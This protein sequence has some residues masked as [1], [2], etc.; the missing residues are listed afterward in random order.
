MNRSQI[1]HTTTT[2][3]IRCIDIIIAL[4]LLILSAPII[5]IFSLIQKLRLRAAF[6]RI[7]L[8]DQQQQLLIVHRLAG[9]N[10]F[11]RLPELLQVVSGKLNLLGSPQRFS[12]ES[13]TVVTL[14]PG[15]IS[16]NDA[17]QKMGLNFQCQQQAL[18]DAHSSA[19]SY[20]LALARITIITALGSQSNLPQ[21]ETFELFGARINNVSMDD[22]L[23]QVMSA[24]TDNTHVSRYAFVNA[25]CMNIAFDNDTYRSSLETCKQVF[26][27][28]LGMRLAAKQAGI[29]LKDNVNGTDMFPLLCQQMAEQGLAIFLLGGRPGIAEQTAQNMQQQFPNLKVAGTH[30]GYL[31]DKQLNQSVIDKINQSGAAV[32]LVAMGAPMQELWLQK[33]QSELQVGVAMGVGGLFDFYSNRIKRAPMWVRQMG[34]EWICRLLAEPKR[35]WRRYIIGNPLF[36]YRVNRYLKQ[37]GAGKAAQT[38]PSQRALSTQGLAH[39]LA[40]QDL[41]YQKAVL[42][43]VT[44]KLALRLNIVAKRIVDVVVAS[45]A[46]LLLSPLFML[47]FMLIRIESPGAVFF[48]QQRAGK[49]NLPFKMWKFRSMY[50]DAQQ[51]LQKLQAQNEMQGGVTFKMKQDPRITRVGRFI[52][53][54]SIDE[55]PQLWNVLKGDMSLVGPRPALLSEVEQYSQHQRRRLNIKPGITCIWQV[56]GRSDIPFDKQVQLDI[57]YIY[58]QSLTADISLLLKTI[59]AVLTARGAY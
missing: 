13:G 28:G 16:F 39:R 41:A 7:E 24:A 22:M 31:A 36:L 20:L 23:T 52:R 18:I 38:P 4:S 3:L 9:D 25:D 35:M 33:H 27:D 2:M 44:H 51:R 57:D 12:F 58:Q 56:S 32:L 42:T 29:S 10:I 11:S 50:T 15:F 48:S 43:R 6:E 45:I 30:H 26:A 14:K 53:K 37:Q 21:S 49:H 1:K 54:A 17:H 40:S 5:A 34:M 19:L 46:L 55:L 59:P 8:L 47:V